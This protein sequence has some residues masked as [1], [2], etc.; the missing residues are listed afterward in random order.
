MC[1]PERTAVVHGLDLKFRSLSNPQCEEVHSLYVKPELHRSS[2]QRFSVR[3]VFLKISQN[4]QENTCAR[5]FFLNKVASLRAATLL[6]RR[7]WFVKFSGTPFLKNT[8]GRLLLIT[9][10]I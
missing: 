8:P 9:L 6:K 3:K 7:L 2:H 1:A 5:V 10:S 4:S